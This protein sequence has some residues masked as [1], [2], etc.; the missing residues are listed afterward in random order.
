MS[1]CK[2]KDKIML[3]GDFD[4][5]LNV[6]FGNLLSVSNE[7]IHILNMNHSHS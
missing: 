4:L 6:Y 3:Q 5:F 7:K 1:V 2:N